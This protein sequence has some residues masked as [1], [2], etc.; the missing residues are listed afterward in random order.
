MV[1]LYIFL[2]GYKLY[3]NFYTCGDERGQ[4]DLINHTET[5][6]T[7]RK[8][9]PPSLQRKTQT[10]REL[11]RYFLDSVVLPTEHITFPFIAWP[12]REI[13]SEIQESV[14]F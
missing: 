5:Q 3:V 13:C 6:R 10:S 4:K 7:R 14:A 1:M 9:L 12:E 8:N 11:L 2:F